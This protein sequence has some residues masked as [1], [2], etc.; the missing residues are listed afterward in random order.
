[1]WPNQEK[2]KEWDKQITTKNTQYIRKDWLRKA[3]TICI[4]NRFCKG[5]KLRG[6]WKERVTLVSPEDISSGWAGGLAALILWT[7][8]MKSYRQKQ[9]QLP[10]PHMAEYFCQLLSIEWMWLLCICQDCHRKYF[11]YCK[12]KGSYG[13]YLRVDSCW[14]G[15]EIKLCDTES[16]FSCVQ[17]RT[18]FNTNDLIH[19]TLLDIL[20]T[21]GR[22]QTIG[23]STKGKITTF[24]M[25]IAKRAERTLSLHYDSQS[26]GS[27]WC[28]L[29]LSCG[30]KYHSDSI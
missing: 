19:Y 29:P 14:R 30:K 23:L 12:Q 6:K 10:L 17:L 1:M 26:F 13:G 22:Y 25:N 7:Q 21:R 16:G 11:I 15:Q 5:D 8:H 24:T 4:A 18:F 27:V 9:R 3:M 28:Y 20:K 2:T